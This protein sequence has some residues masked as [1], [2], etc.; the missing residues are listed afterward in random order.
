MPIL[1]NRQY[2]E[3][4]PLSIKNELKRIDSSY[5]VDGYASTYKPYVLYNTDEGPV[6][7]EFR[8]GCFA[9]TDISDVIMQ[10]DHSGK[11]FARQSSGTLIV[12]PDDVG[13]FIAADLSKSEAARNMYEEISNKLITKMSFGFIPDDYFYDESRRTIVHNSVKKIFDVSA[14]SIPA[15][16]NTNIE[17][18]SFVDGVIDNMTKEIRKRQ[19][20]E[21][22]VRT[23][24]LILLGG[25]TK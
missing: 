7:E 1:Q 14:V 21:E 22:A 3:M 5:Y 24:T 10:F 15:N 4:M 16:D 9:K 17:A 20:H 19:L 11:V 13:L 8:R 23:A 18:R 6:Y 25:I 2:R 12:E